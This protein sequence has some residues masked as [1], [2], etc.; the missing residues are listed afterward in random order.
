MTER[1]NRRSFLAEA[2]ASGAYAYAAASFPATARAISDTRY[3]KGRFAFPQGV[4]SA[5][6]TPRS[7]VLWTRTI[8]TVEPHREVDVVVEVSPSP[9]FEKLI[10]KRQVRAKREFDHTLRVL[11][12]DLQP[13]STYY[14]RFLAGQDRPLHTGR[15]RTAPPYDSVTNFNFAVVSCQNFQT[16]YFTGYRTMRVEDDKADDG[17]KIDFIVH[18]GDFIYEAIYDMPWGAQKG[19]S[20]RLGP[21]DRKIGDFPSGGGQGKGFRFARTVED[22]RHLYRRSLSDPDLQAARAFWPFI[23]TW[24]DHEFT[25]DSWQSHGTYEGN[26]K[27]DPARKMAANQAW[28]EYI[29]A[30]LSG[31]K[32]V[33]GERH[34]AHDFRAADLGPGEDSTA[35]EI[36]QAAF[37][38]KR[39][40]S[41]VSDAVNVKAVE[42]L[43]IYRNLRY[44]ALAEFIVTDNRSYRSDHPVPEELALDLLGSS[45]TGRQGLPVSLVEICDAGKLANDGAPP[46]MLTYNGKTRPN[47]RKESEPGSILGKSQKDWWKQS[48]Q[49]SRA[50][51]RFWVNS[52]PLMPLRF[53]YANDRNGQD[54]IIMSADSWEGYPTER[55]ELLS[56]LASQGISNLISLAGDYHV[57]MAGRLESVTTERAK[58]VGYEFAVG[59]ISSTSIQEVYAMIGSE[60]LAPL[61]TAA[62][63]AEGLDEENGLNL[64]FLKGINTSRKYANASFPE[65]RRIAFEAPKTAT[66]RH[67]RYIDTAAYGYLRMTVT[68]DR[69]SG[70]FVQIERPLANVGKQGASVR[71]RIRLDI[72]AAGRTEMAEPSISG[73]TPFPYSGN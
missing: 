50:G 51:W 66:A 41:K 48:M 53:D 10:V 68:K 42:S 63:L 30:L 25:N 2:L 46:D 40:S 16:G 57:N 54:D 12:D 28:F 33:A 17:E 5:D 72:D 18:V 67:F 39:A 26:G 13:G 4:A 8:D 71:T 6:P 20:R 73:K 11:V 59:G 23:N 15:T 47:P 35:G 64:T 49:Q 70:T 62:P 38:Y 45:T 29:P 1:K 14:Y 21:P 65:R 34:A 69:V 22:Y 61:I 24:D 36:D 3:P 58:R 43:T 7:V 56:F 52:V 19:Q 32:Q 60:E 44:G 9:K 27:F 37:G 31:G 55:E